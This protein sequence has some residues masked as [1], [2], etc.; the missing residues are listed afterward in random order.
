MYQIRYSSST[1]IFLLLCSLDS[2]HISDTSYNE[3][4]MQAL[5]QDT[6]GT[7]LAFVT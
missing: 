7:R 5:Y 1:V 4:A 2:D 3:K 6:D